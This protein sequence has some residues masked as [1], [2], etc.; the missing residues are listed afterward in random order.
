MRELYFGGGRSIIE[1][2]VHLP[3]AKVELALRATVQT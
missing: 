2:A 3:V 1:V